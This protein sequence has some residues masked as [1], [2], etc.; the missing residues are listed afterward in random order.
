MWESVIFQHHELMGIELRLSDLLP[1]G[2]YLQS[3]LT[4]DH[5]SR[6][7][8]AHRDGALW[9]S[10]MPEA[11]LEGEFSDLRF[12]LPKCLWFLSERVLTKLARR[13]LYCWTYIPRSFALFILRQGLTELP[14]LPLSSLYSLG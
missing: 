6:G 12:P 5:Q 11:S 8:T 7:D 10:H 9:P 2:L 1:K 13:V 3:Y 14:R 4:Q